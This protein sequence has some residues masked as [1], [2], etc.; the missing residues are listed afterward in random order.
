MKQPSVP[1]SNVLGITSA[2][3]N[4]NENLTPCLPVLLCPW[5][6]LCR[7]PSG[8]NVSLDRNG[9]RRAGRPLRKLLPELR[10]AFSCLAWGDRGKNKENSIRKKVD[11]TGLPPCR[12]SGG[13]R[14]GRSKP[15]PN[16][17]GARL[18]AQGPAGPKE[19]PPSVPPAQPR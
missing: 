14:R 9:G 8:S 16:R 18:G 12:D 3:A 6:A 19:E 15:G 7:D 1:E 17:A 5:R 11:R 13:W 4:R 2:L 10:S